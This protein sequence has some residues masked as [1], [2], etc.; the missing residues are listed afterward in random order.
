MLQLSNSFCQVDDYANYGSFFVKE[1]EKLL[2]NEE[3]TASCQANMYPKQSP[4]QS[5]VTGAIE[6]P[7][8]QWLE[9]PNWNSEGRE[10]DSHAELGI[11]SELSGVRNLL[12]PN[13]IKHYNQGCSQIPSQALIKRKCTVYTR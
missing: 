2:F 3:I 8:A 9:L 7:V 1:L 10:F 12:L 4:I 5:S 13:Y 11:F 6:P